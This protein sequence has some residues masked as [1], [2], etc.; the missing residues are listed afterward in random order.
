MNPDPRSA[1][2]YEQVSCYLEQA[3]C[4]PPGEEEP[5]LVQVE[6]GG[7]Q[8]P[9]AQIYDPEEVEPGPRAIAHFQPLC[10]TIRSKD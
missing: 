5:L 8:L 2:A 9:G 7:L 4:S 10:H 1:Y 6:D 3:L